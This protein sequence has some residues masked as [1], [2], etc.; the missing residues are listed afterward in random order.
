MTTP[1]Q[2]AAWRLSI[3]IMAGLWIF[4]PIPSLARPVTYA[5][6]WMAMTSNDGYDNGASLLYSPTA[7]TAIG[8]FL[9]H[10]RGT[11]AELAG[12]QFNWL[13]RRWNNPDSQGNFYF[14]SGL[15]VSNDDGHARPGGFAGLE[16]DWEDRRFYVSYENRYTA[17]GDDVKEEFQ[18]RGRVGVAPY[19]AEAGSLHSWLM[20]QLDHAPEDENNWRLTPLL[21][22]FKGDYLA[23]AGISTD[24]H[25]LFNLMITY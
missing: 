24:G 17:A 10:Y 19:V 1:P 23:E 6:G 18:Q 20:L 13:A 21:R 12:L 4:A 16:A 5:G 2:K 15:G 14:L 7:T 3:S 8:P 11:D 25:A 9:N 22:V